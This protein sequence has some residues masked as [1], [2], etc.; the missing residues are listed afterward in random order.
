MQHSVCNTVFAP[1]YLNTVFTTQFLN[2][3]LEHT[4]STQSSNTVLEVVVKN[5]VLLVSGVAHVNTALGLI[6]FVACCL[7]LAGA[8]FVVGVWC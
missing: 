5:T 1:H 6:V 2:L 4:N 7:L 8:W 3:L